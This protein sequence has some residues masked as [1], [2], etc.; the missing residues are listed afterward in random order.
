MEHRRGE[1]KQLVRRLRL[2]HEYI[3][4]GYI[5]PVEHPLSR[6]K[7]QEFPQNSSALPAQGQLQLLAG[8]WHLRRTECAVGENSSDSIGQRIEPERWNSEKALRDNHQLFAKNSQL[9]LLTEKRG[10]EVSHGG[11]QDD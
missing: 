6:G 11:H 4:Y 2:C 1:W 7:N 3:R 10:G 5:R 8:G 9:H